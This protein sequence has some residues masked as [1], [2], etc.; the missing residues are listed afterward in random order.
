MKKEKKKQH[1]TTKLLKGK[2]G[3]FTSLILMHVGQLY[4]GVLLSHITA[5][6]GVMLSDINQR[7]TSDIRLHLRVES[8]E[9]H[10]GA[11]KRETL[12]HRAETSGCQQGGSGVG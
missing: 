9:Q 3:N 10:K 12:A 4:N 1:I 11:N 8:E 5:R 7:K 6:E 2:N